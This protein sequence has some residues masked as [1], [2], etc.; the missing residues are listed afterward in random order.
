MWTSIGALVVAY[1]LGAVPFGY[2]IVR[3][4]VGADVRTTGSGSTGA[5]NV[6]RR[7][8]IKAGAVTYLLD[9]A[10][11]ALAVLLMRAVTDNPL[12]LGA[13]AAA[14]V[15]GHMYPVFLGFRGGKG[16][17]TGVGAY[18]MIVP[19][20]VLTTLIV[21]I[22]L[23]WRTR[24]VSLSSIVA[25]A[26]V[27]LWAGLWILAVTGV[28]LSSPSSLATMAGVGIGCVIIIAKHH[29]NLARLVHGT[30]ARFVRSAPS[31]DEPI[32]N[33]GTDPS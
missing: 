8:G 26:L 31:D 27:P 17:A 32:D 10:K 28:P 20:A 12:W 7:A 24:I 5:T 30:E 6:V 23:F 2:I 11:G 15:V 19:V 22:V 9:V 18:L 33:T 13:A 25:T 4:F 3:L 1:L 16:V 14:V 29:E 21:W